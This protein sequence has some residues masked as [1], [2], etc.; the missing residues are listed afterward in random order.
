MQAL[1]LDSAFPD[2]VQSDRTAAI[3]DQSERNLEKIQSA[4]QDPGGTIESAHCVE[5]GI[6]W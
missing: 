1:P 2:C 6:P 4:K 3:I 5:K